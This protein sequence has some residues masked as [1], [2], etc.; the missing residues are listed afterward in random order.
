MSKVIIEDF[1]QIEVFKDINSSTLD[2]IL[3][4]RVSLQK[5]YVSFYKVQ[6]KIPWELLMLFWVMRG[7]Y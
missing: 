7:I 3:I 5:P 6:T 4:L 1:K 2:S